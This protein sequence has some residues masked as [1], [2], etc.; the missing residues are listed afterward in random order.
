VAAAIL[1]VGAL[2][3]CA[4]PQDERSMKASAVRAD[5][6]SSGGDLAVAQE[7]V[8]EQ[9]ASEP[10]DGLLE[11]E[12][13]ASPAGHVALQRG[14]AAPA[15]PPPSPRELTGRVLKTSGSSGTPPAAAQASDPAVAR[16]TAA[17]EQRPSLIYD[18]RVHLAVFETAQAIDAAETLA[19]E[20]QGYLVHR[21]D[22]VITFRVP[23]ASFDA[24]LAAATKLGDV[25]HREVTV[26]DVT[27]EFR[28]LRVRL[29]SAEAVRDRLEQLLAR[30]D[31]VDQALQV[32]RE[33][34]RVAREIEQIKGRLAV[35]A[36]LTA[37]STITLQFQ[38]RP[39]DAI[40]TQVKLPF[41]WLERLG[42]AELLR[43]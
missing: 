19:R 22:R 26:R 11:A 20:N 4:V 9:T 2:S 21:S 13:E 37:F 40:D 8:S 18:A 3:G 32:E 6:E 27:E 39:I 16:D 12:G 43:L 1:L 7:V 42:L 15:P 23:S 35:L 17:P 38:P 5:R 25:L 41:P 34:E 10:V 14:P 30:A 33:L 31:K 29:R 36:E 28:D 24:T